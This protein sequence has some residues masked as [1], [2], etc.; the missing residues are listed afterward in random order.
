MPC[1]HMNPNREAVW[2][3][4]LGSPYVDVLARGRGSR[5]E[6]RV[7]RV[8]FSAECFHVPKLSVSSTESDDGDLPS[9]RL[10]TSRVT[11]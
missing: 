9:M 10:A 4:F 1:S 7:V 11:L 8:K 5:V 3:N 6:V 2:V